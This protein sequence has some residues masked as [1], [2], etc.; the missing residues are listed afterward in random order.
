MQPGEIETL[1]LELLI[2]AIYRRYG[3]D[4]RHYARASLARRLSLFLSK[5]GC[6]TP[7][8]IIPQILHDKVFFQSMIRHIS[9]TVTE[10]FRDPLVYQAIRKTLVDYLKTYPFIRIWHAGC[11]T[12]EEVYSMAI[13]LSEERLYNRCQIYATDFNDE[14]LETAKKGTYPASRLKEYTANYQ[15]SGG[16]ESFSQ[17]YHSQYESAIMDRALKENIVFA[18]HNLSSDSVFSEMQLIMCRNVLIYFDQALQDRAL[19]LFYDS[20][21]HNGLL[22]LGAKE[23]IKFSKYSNNFIDFSTTH[24]IF[25]K[26]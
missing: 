11:S 2:D 19:G 10:M 15:K 9:V 14:A 4:F 18:N 24:K 20:L 16:K 22:C 6:K 8:E 1:E 17:Y 13:L 21:V 3:Y 5:T 23:T 25:Q 7:S 26:R 12:G